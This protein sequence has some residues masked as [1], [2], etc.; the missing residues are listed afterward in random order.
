M[1]DDGTHGGFAAVQNGNMTISG[2]IFDGKL[3]GKFTNAC[4]G[5]VGW[6]NGNLTIN[7]SVFNPAGIT[8]DK[9]S[10][11]TFAR[12]GGT[13]NNCYYFTEL[14]DTRNYTGQGRRAHSIIGS[15]GVNVSLSG[16][17]KEY[18]TAGLTAYEPGVIYNGVSYAANGDIVT[19]AI[20]SGWE[21]IRSLL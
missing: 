5:F 19:L 21:E 20:S 4:G 3:T 7:D 16:D 17:G 14:N 12:N 18:N 1:F 13:F 2:C 10:C 15:D 8:L 6:N 9:T 11:A